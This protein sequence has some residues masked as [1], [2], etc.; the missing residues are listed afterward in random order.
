MNL[1]EYI[2][3]NI[4]KLPAFIINVLTFLLGFVC[5][6]F[7]SS[8]S[9]IFVYIIA[10]MIMLPTIAYIIYSL[11]RWKSIPFPVVD[12]VFSSMIVI[13]CIWAIC[14]P[15]SVLKLFIGAIGVITMV[16]AI[17]WLVSA[18]YEYQSK[19]EWIKNALVGSIELIIGIIILFNPFE[20]IKIAF[21]AL[22][23]YLMLIAIFNIYINY[24][25]NKRPS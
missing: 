1:K 21:I 18:Y 23:L 7:S 22:G 25:E 9:S 24:K 2:K 16:S 14:N 19:V 20:T 8:I 5:L 17:K 12:I 11:I 13:V 10:S 15:G 6:I 3:N 4:N